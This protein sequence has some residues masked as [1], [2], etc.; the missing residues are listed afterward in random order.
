MVAP[1]EYKGIPSI[2]I[3]NFS[4]RVLLSQISAFNAELK[5]T[6]DNENLK[7]L[8]LGWTL[9][10]G[11][12]KPL[13]ITPTKGQVGLLSGRQDLDVP[14]YFVPIPNSGNN[15]PQFILEMLE[16]LRT[17]LP[18][19]LSEPMDGVT[20]LRFDR[21]FV[22]GKEGIRLQAETT[23]RYSLSLRE[24]MNLISVPLQPE[25]WRLQ[26]PQEP[27]KLSDLAEYIGLADVSMIIFRDEEKGKFV[28]WKPEFPE[29]SPINAPV[30]GGKGYIVIMKSPR[31]V[32]FTGSGWD[33]RVELQAGVNCIS[34]PL[35]PGEK[36][37]KL[38]DLT[39]CIGAE[40]NVIVRYDAESRKYISWTPN[41]PKDSPTNVVI[42]GGDG[43]IV[44]MK[45]AKSV[46][47]TG[48]AWE[49]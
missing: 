7:M 46:T 32:T 15:E 18:R 30:E 42:K 19:P 36:W 21:V 9:Y 35:D 48:K 16:P 39:E 14:P 25:V 10:P 31:E 22:E 49:N 24:G 23:N 40:V 47:F 5:V 8:L 33:G 44:V 20:N 45:R 4:G 28:T 37:K 12:G 26:P 13:Y 6:D 27:W 43:F 1:N 34:M 29:E 38:S 17:Q 3:D 11:K 41:S 2:E